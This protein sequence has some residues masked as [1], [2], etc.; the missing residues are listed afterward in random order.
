MQTRINEIFKKV[1]DI[2][3]SPEYKY[4]ET[5]IVMAASKMQSCE[6]IAVAKA[7]GVSHFGENRMQEWRDKKDM[8]I[9]FDFIGALQ[10][11]KLKYLVGEVGTIQS[12]SSEKL[13][14]ECDNVAKKKGVVQNILLEVNIGGE[15]QKS[16][17][18]DTQVEEITKKAMQLQNVVLKGYMTVL[19][20]LENQNGENLY[21]Q[22]REIY[23][24]Q[25]AIYP[26]IEVLSMGMSDDFEDA[27][28]YGS[29]MVRIGT[30]L[31][32]ER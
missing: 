30:A 25:K 28:K 12:I 22:M 19:P 31:F 5:P 26:Q 11:N 1:N 29:T 21:L 3:S 24:K 13:L 16:G 10:S 17:I 4:N 9:T 7:C 20:K 8:D 15:E 2:I 14:F 6:N 27:I 23:D 18:A 32:G